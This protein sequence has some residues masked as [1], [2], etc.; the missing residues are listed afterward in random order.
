M[1]GPID[2]AQASLDQGSLRKALQRLGWVANRARQARALGA[3]GI[4][5]MRFDASAMGDTWSEICAC[6]TAVTIRKA[7]SV[8]K[9]EGSD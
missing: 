1:A 9:S 5:S 7:D 4:V 8:P 2:E 3:N 6:G